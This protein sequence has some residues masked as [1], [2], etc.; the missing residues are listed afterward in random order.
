MMTQRQEALLASII[1]EY[2]E[3]AKPVSSKFLEKMG[4][5]GLSSAT[6]RAEMNELEK[7]GYL[8][9]LYT[10]SGRVPTDK[11][12]R[13]F[14]DNLLGEEECELTADYKRKIKMVLQKTEKEPREINKTVAQLLSELSDNLVIAGI[15]E[16]SEFFKVGLSSLFEFPEFREFERAFR[17]ADFFDEFEEVFNRLEKM[18]WGSLAVTNEDEGE[19]IKIFIGRENPVRDIRDETV[20]LARYN[21]PFN[22]KGSLTLIGPTR[23]D[24]GK[25]I[26]L[27]RYTTRELNK[28]SREI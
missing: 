4:F 20:M 10:S 26:G 1:K 15:P 21:L 13:F 14:V 9:H 2:I 28:L 27:I 12:Y 23:M 19:D 6:I 16:Q 18:F 25:N 22:Y 7:Q 5:F 17:L 8:T 3:T 11:A 24:Y